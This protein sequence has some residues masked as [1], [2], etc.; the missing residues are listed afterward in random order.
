MA[1]W[2]G[3]QDGSTGKDT[4]R[5]P[6]GEP[7]Q[8]PARRTEGHS[9]EGLGARGRSRPLWAVLGRSGPSW[10]LAVTFTWD[11]LFSQHKAKAKGQDKAKKWGSQGAWEPGVWEPARGLAAG[12]PSTCRGVRTHQLPV[13][14]PR[15]QPVPPLIRFLG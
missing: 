12:S 5:E 13:F 11:T 1:S 10:A 4:A 14:L 15:S 7:A 9:R 8:R 6:E 2:S 3:E